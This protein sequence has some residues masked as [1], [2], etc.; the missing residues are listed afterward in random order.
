MRPG[1]PPAD[2]Y[3]RLDALAATAH[4]GSGKAIFTPWLHGERSP[5][6]DPT[7]RGGWHNLKPAHHPQRL[8]A[9]RLR[10][11][12]AQHAVGG[13]P[14]WRNSPGLLLE[15]VRLVGGGGRSDIWCRVPRRRTAAA[16]APGGRSAAHQ[17]AWCC[18]PG[19]GGTRLHGPARLARR[20]RSRRPTRRAGWPASIMNCLASLW[21]F[22][23]RRTASI[24][25]STVAMP[26][27]FYSFGQLE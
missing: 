23:R 25:A 4:P 24:A 22:T 19:R 27:R 16:G 14:T 10:G 9:Q 15:S 21:R 8:G 11:R 13:R 5:V 2:A 17:Y 26:G 12:G 18:V 3:A 20:R 1:G 6:D 7:L